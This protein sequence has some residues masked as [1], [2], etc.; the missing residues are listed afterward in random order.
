[1]AFEQD[2]RRGPVPSART[3]LE[4]WVAVEPIEPD[5]SD[6]SRQK[7]SNVPRRGRCA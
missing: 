4:A 7:R 2:R 6:H 5:R 3:A 1:M